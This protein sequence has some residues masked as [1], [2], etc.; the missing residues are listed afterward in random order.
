MAPPP[1]PPWY[2][3]TAENNPSSHQDA[4]A[5]F[6]TSGRESYN[7]SEDEDEEPLLFFPQTLSF[8]FPPFIRLSLPPPIHVI[9]RALMRSRSVIVR[10]LSTASGLGGARRS[11]GCL[12]YSLHFLKPAANKPL[13]IDP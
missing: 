6:L 4:L 12:T 2:N 1:T 8:D 5:Y 10:S 13:T 3:T 11:I 9:Q 7:L